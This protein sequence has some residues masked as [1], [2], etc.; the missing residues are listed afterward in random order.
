M[1]QHP[2]HEP[3]GDE[4]PVP[5][6]ECLY[7]GEIDLT[8]AIIQ[9]TEL[10]DVIGDAIGEAE[11]SGGELPLWGV[12]VLARALANEREDPLSGAL[13]TFAA[14][15]FASINNVMYELAEV[16]DRATSPQV[17]EW[18]NWLGITIVRLQET[19]AVTVQ[20]YTKRGLPEEAD[21]HEWLATPRDARVMAAV[22]AIFLEPASEMAR[23]AETDDANPILLHN[24]LRSI[25]HLQDD[26]PAVGTWITNLE[27]HLASR[28]DLGRRTSPDEPADEQ[29]STPADAAALDDP[30]AKRAIKVFGDP[31]RAYLELPDVDPGGHDLAIGF[32]DAYVGSADSMAEVRTVV[33]KL[34]DPT[35]EG[36]WPPTLADDTVVNWAAHLAWDIVELDGR[37]YLFTKP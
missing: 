28:I 16:H 9:D 21:D 36:T 5:E 13:H 10:A 6:S 33:R 25:T 17:V 12:R 7:P 30:R 2:P 29:L 37:L 35:D 1:E 19:A 14:T 24:E 20:Q 26:L 34:V 27:R 32:Q 22:L 11:A 15:G 18:V 3:T 4:G 23:F 31:L 8:G